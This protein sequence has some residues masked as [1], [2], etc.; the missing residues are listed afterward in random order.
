M[1]RRIPE[2]ET[3]ID[4]TELRLLGL[5]SEL[6]APTPWSGQDAGLPDAGKGTWQQPLWRQTRGS[7]QC[8]Q[9]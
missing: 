8:D 5:L 6:V 3:T 1:A 4:D 9:C 7:L 2:P